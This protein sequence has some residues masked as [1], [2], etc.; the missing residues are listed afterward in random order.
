MKY[1]ADEPLV[2]KQEH[3]LPLSVCALVPVR[4]ERANKLLGIRRP[5]RDG[6]GSM[7]RVV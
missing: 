1:A 4:A 7:S 6:R 3:S 2:L 5:S